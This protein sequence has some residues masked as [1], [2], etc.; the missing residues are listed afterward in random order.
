VA[1]KSG[2][3]GESEL[4]IDGSQMRVD[5]VGRAAQGGA[6]LFVR[7]TLFDPVSYTTASALVVGR[8]TWSCRR[9]V[10]LGPRVTRERGDVAR[11]LRRSMTEGFGSRE[12]E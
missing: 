7:Q 8:S 2:A 9:P 3:V 4:A 11:A 10:S 6:G 1:G 5:G 12:I